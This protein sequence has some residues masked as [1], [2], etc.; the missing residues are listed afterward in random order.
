MGQVTTEAGQ[1]VEGG[2]ILDSLRDDAKSQC[3]AERD[4]GFNQL[5]ITSILASDTSDKRAVELELADR[6][7]AEM[8]Q[9]SEARPE[10]VD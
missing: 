5:L 3:M 6:E 7:A 10:V 8:R 1:H 2:A 4:G 9:R